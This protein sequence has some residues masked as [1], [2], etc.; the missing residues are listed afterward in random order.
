MVNKIRF[1][2]RSVED[3]DAIIQFYDEQN[4][5]DSAIEKVYNAI[6]TRIESLREFSDRG[7][8]VPEFWDEGVYKY[9]ELIEGYSRII[10]RKTENTVTI[11]RVLDSRNLNNFENV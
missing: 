4:L 6:I 10:Y 5:S 8:I 3:I 7:R 1:S 9:R 11:I 2:P